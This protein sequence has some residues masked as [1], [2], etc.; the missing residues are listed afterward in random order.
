MKKLAKIL[1]A[2]ILSMLLAS[3]ILGGVLEGVQGV[4]GAPFLMIFGWFYFPV[5]FG[6]NAV[7]FE[8]WERFFSRMPHGRA[9]LTLIG[10]VVAAALFSV[11]GIKIQDSEPPSTVG[12]ALGAS[13]AAMATCLWISRERTAKLDQAELK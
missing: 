6:L 8:F 3:A 7:A 5:V 11:I 12:Y 9:Y 1:I 2:S 10:G 4:L 13:V